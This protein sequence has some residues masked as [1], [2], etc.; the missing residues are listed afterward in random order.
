MHEWEV[1]N[2][3]S[4]EKA[5][6]D[7]EEDREYKKLLAGGS[8]TVKMGAREGGSGCQQWGWQ[9]GR[10]RTGVNVDRDTLSLTK[11]QGHAGS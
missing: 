11:H 5:S 10:D 1:T 2:E 7:G 8:R 9:C 6:L 4:S 3:N